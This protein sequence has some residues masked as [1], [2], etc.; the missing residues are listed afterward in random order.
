MVT[1]HQGQLCERELV[2]RPLGLRKTYR[3]FSG[4]DE[5]DRGMGAG[6]AAA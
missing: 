2:A 4:A 5:E 1:C 6:G 3:H